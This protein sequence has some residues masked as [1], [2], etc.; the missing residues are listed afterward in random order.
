MSVANDSVKN[1]LI[2]GGGIVGWMAAAF[3]NRTLRG[4]GCSVTL[5]ESIKLETSAVGE[6]TLPTL[7][8]FLRGFRIDETR[9]M[10]QCSATYKLGTRYVNWMRDGQEFWHPHGLAGGTI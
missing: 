5:V 7:V 6:A 8:K 2:V 10:Q 1:I 3:L 4:A 9:L